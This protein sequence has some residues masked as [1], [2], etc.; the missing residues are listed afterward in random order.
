MTD[1]IVPEGFRKVEVPRI[2]TMSG[3][4]N[5]LWQMILMHEFLL[6]ETRKGRIEN[7]GHFTNSI[8]RHPKKTRNVLNDLIGKVDALLVGAG[9]A[10]QLTGCANALLRNEFEDD[11]IV[12][13]GFAIEDPE[14]LIHTQ[15]AVRSITELPSSEVVFN[16]YVGEEGCLRA[17]MDAAKG[18]YPVI[19]LKDY[20]ALAVHR[21]MEEAVRIGKELK[22]S[23]QKKQGGNK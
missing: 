11:Y 9:W 10:N 19:N 7:L 8:H 17:A 14:N 23:I 15:T 6:E 18:I 22:L 20:S 12:V 5:D 3:S 1:L 13:Y 21:S 4:S 2:A 16:N